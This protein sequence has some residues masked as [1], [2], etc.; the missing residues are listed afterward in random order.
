MNNL[1]Y[2]GKYLKTDDIYQI[3]YNPELDKYYSL[4]NEVLTKIKEANKGLE[5]IADLMPND[6]EEP[7]LIPYEITDTNEIKA[8]NIFYQKRVSL[9]KEENER[10][11]KEIKEKEKQTRIRKGI[12]CGA[13][14]ITFLA[15]LKG[16]Y[17]KYEEQ[18]KASTNKYINNLSTEEDKKNAYLKDITDALTLNE[19]LNDDIKS[20]WIN[21]FTSL[22]S[23]DIFIPK[24]KVKDIISSINNGDYSKAT[25]DNHIIFLSSLIF[26]D[27]NYPFYG[28]TMQLDEYAN[29]LE[30][31][32]SSIDFAYLYLN[33]NDDIL[34]QIFLGN[35]RIYSVISS[36]LNASESTI[37]DTLKGIKYTYD[38]DE[39]T[40]EFYHSNV[41]KVIGNILVN[42]YKGKGKLSEFDQLVLGSNLFNPTSDNIIIKY[43][44]FSDIITVTIND[45][46]YGEYNLYFDRE[47]KANI[48]KV[49]YQEKLTNLIKEKGSNIDYN[50]S[51]CRFIIYLYYLSYIDKISYDV[52]EELI[53]PESIEE[54]SSYLINSVFDDGILT[55]DNFVHL[56]PEVLYS[57]FTNGNISF[58][59]ILKR[60]R[61]LANNEFAM[62]LFT[63]FERALKHDLLLGNI[64]TEEY[65]N[66]FS[67]V[68]YWLTRRN[69][70]LYNYL[71]SSINQDV[72]LVDNFTIPLDSNSCEESEVK[73]LIK[74]Y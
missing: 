53:N 17:N 26:N 36:S 25:L 11:E 40:Y 34:N 56:N 38:T 70:D 59:D 8:L 61:S 13:L 55:G 31:R 19:T 32:K 72:S 7:E 1:I 39:E 54:F 63:E 58:P 62:T 27:N 67:E 64:T 49:I 30:P 18:I 66:Q 4:P 44:I 9:I 12:F 68:T 20:L 69:P 2:L 48:T 37:E 15:S 41:S 5:V 28:I 35:D 10:K 45:A 42:Y 46:T 51:D 47:T 16:L 23:R 43:N 52:D 65:N 50:D 71:K 29:N 6:F 14:I 73:D 57:Y 60:I 24:H 22:F 33:L 3:Y 21:D 74:S